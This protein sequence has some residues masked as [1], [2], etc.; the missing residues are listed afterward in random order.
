MS[1]EPMTEAE[2]R[3]QLRASKR[4]EVVCRGC[5]RAFTPAHGKRRHCSD[6]CKQKAYRLRRGRNT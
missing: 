2:Y 4:T 6:R 5:G 3:K 1:T